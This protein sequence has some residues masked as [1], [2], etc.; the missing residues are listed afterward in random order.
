L[1]ANDLLSEQS[2]ERDWRRIFQIWPN[3]LEVR[4]A[5]R[6]GGARPLLP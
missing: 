5:I 3:D 1:K 4:P 6:S 2:R